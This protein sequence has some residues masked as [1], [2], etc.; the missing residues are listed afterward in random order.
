MSLA[1]F[2]IEMGSEL[3]FV[4]TRRRSWACACCLSSLFACP[5]EEPSP[6]SGDLYWSA[7]VEY[8]L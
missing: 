5:K 4:K 7:T 8:S 2:F 3:A 6:L 1:I